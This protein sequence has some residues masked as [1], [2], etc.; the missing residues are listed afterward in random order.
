MEIDESFHTEPKAMKP[1]MTQDLKKEETLL[2]STQKRTE[3]IMMKPITL[4]KLVSV[5]LP[6]KKI[7]PEVL[8]KHEAFEIVNELLIKHDF[9]TTIGILST[10]LMFNKKYRINS[11]RDRAQELIIAVYQQ[12]VRDWVNSFGG[13]IFFKLPPT[14]DGEPV[15]LQ[16]REQKLGKRSSTTRKRSPKLG[17]PGGPPF[18]APRAHALANS[19]TPRSGT[20]PR[21]FS[22]FSAPDMC[23]RAP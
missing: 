6:L 21:A 18:A 1:P 22:C 20:E 23:S 8:P 19:R 10:M 15:W 3:K 5:Q 9:K 7:N 4:Q 14:N 2:E 17:P 11:V 16:A 13:N 12:E